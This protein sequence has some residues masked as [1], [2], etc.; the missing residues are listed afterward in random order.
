MFKNLQRRL[1][2][3][4]DWYNTFQKR[5]PLITDIEIKNKLLAQNL[6]KACEEKDGILT[7][8]E[9][10]TV[11][12]FGAN[13][14][15]AVNKRHGQ[16]DIDHRWGP[17]IAKY[18]KKSGHKT[19][20]EFGCGTGELG[21]ATCKEYKQITNEKLTWIGVEIDKKLHKKIYDNFRKNSLQ[22][23]IGAIVT[24]LDDIPNIQNALIVFPYSLDNIPPQVFL[25]MQN[26]SNKPDALLG[27]SVKNGMLSEEI[28]PPNILHKK[29]I[30]LADGLFTQNDY[31]YKLTGWKLRKGQR[32]YLATDVFSTLYY[33]AK[34]FKN[35]TFIIIDEL[36]NEQWNFGLANLGTPKSLYEKNL[37]CDERIR[38]YREGSKH[39]LYYPMFNIS[40]HKFLH[41]IGFRSIE[42]E[43]EQ[44]LAANLN[45]KG[46]YPFRKK[47][48]T[49]AFIAK[50]FVEKKITAMPI[51][52][53]QK[54]IL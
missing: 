53:S 37:P 13:G 21:V 10:L 3:G 17:A 54:R 40:L 26:T 7:Y 9:Y 27:I 46:W 20:I 4:I 11:E 35:A 15:Y 14:Y 16:T 22:N 51:P 19:I 1:A 29:G 28:I 32:L 47:F 41:M 36:K 24:T 42:Y 38:Y 25:N 5:I 6:E 23:Y 2:L 33:S 45:D 34:K 8:A 49:Y 12:Q 39:N 31:T 43:I 48:T 52:S 18:C 50:Q 30:T 44:K